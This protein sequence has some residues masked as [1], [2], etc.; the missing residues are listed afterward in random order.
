MNV[1]AK[2]WLAVWG[3]FCTV[4]LSSVAIADSGEDL[5]KK[6]A[7]PIASLISVPFQYNFDRDIGSAGGYRSL[8]NIQPV[9]PFELNKDWNIISRTILPVVDQHNIAGQSG[10]QSGIG[11]VLQ[12]LFFSPKLPTAGG[13][14]WGAGPVFQLPTASDSLLGSKKWGL[15]PTA[16]VLVQKGPW[17]YGALANHI[18]SV[19][20]DNNQPD[21]NS[22]YLQPFLAYVTPSKTTWSA[23]TESTYNWVAHDWSVP[24]NFGVSQ[25]FVVGKQP[26][27]LGVLARYW[28]RAPSSGPHGWGVR[29]QYT[30]LFPR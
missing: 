25:L 29:V 8:L 10:N 28:A 12:S 11:N 24:I 27:Q 19:A 22:T 2:L 26:M 6:L 5:A 4:A 18:W 21:I 3:L 20:G 7:N 15:G 23:N 17:T 13:M 1:N 9:I 14:V 30:L 16:V